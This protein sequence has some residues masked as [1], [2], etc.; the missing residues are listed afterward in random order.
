MASEEFT[1]YRCDRCH[2]VLETRGPRGFPDDWVAI[3]G[4][5]IWQNTGKLSADLCSEYRAS[6]CEWWGITDPPFKCCRH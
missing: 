5:G 6:L 3:N 2:T 4:V 1:R